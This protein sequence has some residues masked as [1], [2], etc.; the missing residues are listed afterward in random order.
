M[1]NKLLKD[2][3]P[4]IVDRDV[5]Y[6]T[7][8]STARSVL[9]LGNLKELLSIVRTLTLTLTLTTLILRCRCI[10]VCGVVPA[11]S[12]P[13]PCPS[14]R[15]FSRGSRDEVLECLS[16]IAR[17]GAHAERVLLALGYVLVGILPAVMPDGRLHAQPIVSLLRWIGLLA[18]LM[19]PLRL[20]LFQLQPLCE[21]LV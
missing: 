14:T 17:T 4:A 9:T 10:V 2:F 19:P 3:L 6:S 18:R 16:E 1:V 20:L 15:N 13:E 12:P 8:S 11:T 7:K 5:S 21:L